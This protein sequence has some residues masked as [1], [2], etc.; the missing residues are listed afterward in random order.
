MAVNLRVSKS[1]GGSSSQDTHGI[2]WIWPVAKHSFFRM[3][4]WC[5]SWFKYTLLH[6]H[7]HILQPGLYAY[8]MFCQNICLRPFDFND[9]LHTCRTPL[10]TDMQKEPKSLGLI[11]YLTNKHL[12]T[13]SSCSIVYYR[14]ML[15]YSPVSAGHGQF[16][17]LQAYQ[18]IKSQ[19]NPNEIV[20]SL[21]IPIELR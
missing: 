14:A 17:D 19:W 13:E 5:S 15:I 16:G 2:P 18:I 10:L 3:Y 4:G 20:I 9:P 12:C 8:N 21:I 11:E 1:P 6:L 7:N